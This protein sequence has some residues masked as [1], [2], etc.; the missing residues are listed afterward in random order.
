MGPWRSVSFGSFFRLIGV[1]VGDRGAPLQIG[2]GDYNLILPK[3]ARQN[4]K[5]TFFCTRAVER[6]IE[7]K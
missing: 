1:S 7:I 5:A 3:R 2:S 6:N 4:I